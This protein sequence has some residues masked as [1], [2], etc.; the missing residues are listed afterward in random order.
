MSLRVFVR[1]EDRD[2][3][4]ALSVT[5]SPEALVSD[6]LQASLPLFFPPSALP[7]PSE[8]QV[9]VAETGEVLKNRQAVKDTADNP[10][11]V[12]FILRKRQQ[13][14]LSPPPRY[15]T[16]PRCDERV[17]AVSPC[18]AVTPPHAK[19]RTTPATV[20]HLCG[21]RANIADLSGVSPSPA[22][23]DRSVS[24]SGRRVVATAVRATTSILPTD[25]QQPCQPTGTRRDDGLTLLGGTVHR[26]IDPPR[27]RNVY[28]GSPPPHMKSSAGDWWGH[29]GGYGSQV[30]V[31]NH[32]TTRAWQDGDEGLA[33]TWQHPV[34]PNRK[35]LGLPVTRDSSL[36]AEAAHVTPSATASPPQKLHTGRR[37]VAHRD[38]VLEGDLSP[39]SAK[40][41]GL[42]ILGS[43]SQRASQSPQ[44]HYG[45]GAGL[46]EQV[47]RSTI[48]LPG[49]PPSPE[50]SP[51]KMR[52]HNT[53]VS[54]IHHLLSSDRSPSP[55]DPP[56]ETLEEAMKRKG[57]AAPPSSYGVAPQS[58]RCVDVPPVRPSQTAELRR[59]IA[60]RVSLSGGNGGRGE[61]VSAWRHLF[62]A[63]AGDGG[64]PAAEFC[65]AFRKVFNVDIRCTDLPKLLG[66]DRV[67]LVTFR[68]FTQL[69]TEPT[70]SAFEITTPPPKHL[71]GRLMYGDR[72]IRCKGGSWA[73]T[74]QPP[75]GT[76][77]DPAPAPTFGRAQVRS[78]TV[79]P[80]LF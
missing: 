14:P 2:N 57:R 66:T 62:P 8:I 24:P 42:R 80:M 11:D 7:L 65:D 53:H 38:D 43:P 13:E 51:S 33:G 56:A 19:R 52:I 23:D 35:G 28:G 54:T 67:D 73:K 18:T 77:G 60:E 20:Q 25:M 15:Q 74:T 10:T 41:T 26:P 16:P 29:R 36:V 61:L 44:R 78:Q 47:G 12:T 72:G 71:E 17:Q 5:L 49:S 32:S 21:S 63:K 50:A 70:G 46:R 22:A 40:P 48:P 6:L 64:V 4:D 45:L 59:V 79:G 9:V 76:L 31:H 69:C 1:T 55:N 30:R 39:P 68:L 34:V 27:V 75:Y 58:A 3:D 37:L